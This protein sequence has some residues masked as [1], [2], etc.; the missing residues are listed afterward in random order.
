MLARLSST[1]L[2]HINLCGELPGGGAV[3]REDRRAVTW[4]GDTVLQ[5]SY[6]YKG[7]IREWFKLMGW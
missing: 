3:G 5:E 2:A 7:L 4:T 1:H 6:H